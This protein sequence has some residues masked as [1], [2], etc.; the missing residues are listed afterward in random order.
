MNVHGLVKYWLAATRVSPSVPPDMR[1]SSPSVLWR[2]PLVELHNEVSEEDLSHLSISLR[3]RIFRLL[4]LDAAPIGPWAAR[5][6]GLAARTGRIGLAMAL[7]YTWVDALEPSPQLAARGRRLLKVEMLLSRRL[8]QWQRQWPR[9]V[10]NYHEQPAWVI[11]ALL[12]RLRMMGENS[13]IIVYSGGHI[14]AP[15]PW[16]WQF[17]EYATNPESVSLVGVVDDD[18]M[19]SAI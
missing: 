3:N 5:A 18:P 4:E 7:L 8:V 13:A 12:K 6:I 9:Q 19:L 17:P 1:V 16:V 15:Q 11:P 14:L 2:A 10:M